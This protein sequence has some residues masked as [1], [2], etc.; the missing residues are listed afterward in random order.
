[1]NVETTRTLINAGVSAQE[2]L[3]I[4]QAIHLEVANAKADMSVKLFESERW[5]CL[6]LM[7]TFLLSLFWTAA[8]DR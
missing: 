6:A 2:A 3:A 4:S 5:L 1:M 7:A 8:L